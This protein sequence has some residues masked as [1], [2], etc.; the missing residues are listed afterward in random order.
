[1]RLHLVI[2]LLLFATT[3]GY[4]QVPESQRKTMAP[5]TQDRLRWEL[6]ADGESSVG[7]DSDNGVPSNLAGSSGNFLFQLDF[8]PLLDYRGGAARRSTHARAVVGVIGAPQAITAR[9]DP[10]NSDAVASLTAQGSTVTPPATPV[11]TPSLTR[12]RAF[13]FGGEYS[14]NYLLQAGGG[15]VFGELGALIRLNFDAF[16]DDERFFEKDGLT[17]VKVANGLDTGGG[18]YRFEAGGRFRISNGEM[19]FMPVAAGGNVDDLLLVEAVYR[20]AGATKGLRTDTNTAHRFTWRAV[21]TPRI[22]HPKDTETNTVKAV[23]GI[24]VDQDL[25]RKTPVDIR[26]F[27]GTNLNLEALFKK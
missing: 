17:Y 5:D 22:H 6:V 2:L 15:G 9:A 19:R 27:Y 4:A 18:N 26:V 24:E 25:A 11:A 14:D 10:A 1:M 21:A 16:I 20:Y 12:Q 3:T 8:Q 23:I 13:T 7:S